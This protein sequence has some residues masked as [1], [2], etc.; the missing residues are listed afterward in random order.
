MIIIP[1]G[2]GTSSSQGT[3]TA[4][5][6]GSGP[7]FWSG[8]IENIARIMYEL[9]VHFCPPGAATGGVLGYLFGNRG[10][11]SLSQI[12][13]SA[14]V[15]YFDLSLSLLNAQSW[16]E[17]WLLLGWSWLFLWS[18]TLHWWMGW[19]VGLWLQWRMGW[20]KW[21]QLRPKEE[22]WIQFT[23]YFRY[24]MKKLPHP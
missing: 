1:S 9:M 18:L 6:A 12:F 10:S 19:W 16:L 23:N 11:E 17:L 5:G 8:T 24:N 14:C 4:G 15:P 22:W 13:C 20:R 3:G 21:F 2:D 7:G